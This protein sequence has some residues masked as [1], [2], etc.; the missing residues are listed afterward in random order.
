ME[1]LLLQLQSSNIY[2]SSLCVSNCAVHHSH[3][4]PGL[5]LREPPATRGYR[6]SVSCHTPPVSNALYLHEAN[7]YLMEQEKREGKDLPKSQVWV[8][9]TSMGSEVP[10][11]LKV[12][13]A[14]CVVH[15]IHRPC[16][17]GWFRLRVMTQSQEMSIWMVL[18]GFEGFWL[19]CSQVIST[20]SGLSRFG[21]GSGGRH[22]LLWI[23]GL[24]QQAKPSKASFS[25]HFN[26]HVIQSVTKLSDFP[27]IFILLLL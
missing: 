22:C 7:V 10:A 8:F 18:I 6:H 19:W 3:T 9:P 23:V 1:S 5:S 14:P 13:A 2:E 4:R 26:H 24:R 21:G 25:F 12:G 16:L 15:S 27:L 20:C 17:C 11:S